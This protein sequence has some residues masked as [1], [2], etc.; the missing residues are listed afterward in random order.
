MGKYNK[1]NIKLGDNSIEQIDFDRNVASFEIVPSMKTN[2]QQ[3]P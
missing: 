2:I 3:Q 1:W